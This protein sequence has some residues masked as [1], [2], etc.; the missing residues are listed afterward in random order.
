MK[1]V[2]F[3]LALVACSSNQ[4]ASTI[5]TTLNAVNAAEAGFV[6]FD[7]KHQLDIVSASTSHDDA[8]AKLADYRAKRELVVVALTGAY[9]ALKVAAEVNDDPSVAGAV[10]AAALLAADLKT[11]GVTP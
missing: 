7:G 11:L 9:D 2:I 4:R 1:A 8:V 6:A 5:T 3:V 10:A